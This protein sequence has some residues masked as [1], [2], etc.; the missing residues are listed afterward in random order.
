MNLFLDEQDVLDSVHVFIASQDNHGRVEGSAPHNV[1]DVQVSYEERHG[2]SAKGS[3]YGKQHYLNQQ[4][5]ID[6]VSVYLSS[7]YSFRADRLLVKMNWDDSSRSF[8]ADV[9]VER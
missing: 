4:Q 6:A 1:H 7:Y 5:V 8:S 3:I 2:F 9:I